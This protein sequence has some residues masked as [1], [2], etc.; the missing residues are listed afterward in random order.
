[1][2]FGGYFLGRKK[3]WVELMRKGFNEWEEINKLAR[4]NTFCLGCRTKKMGLRNE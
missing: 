2:Y 3:A 4:E 1:M